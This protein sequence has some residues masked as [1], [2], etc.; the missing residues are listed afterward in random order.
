VLAGRILYEKLMGDINNPRGNFVHL[1]P[2]EL[3]T[4]YFWDKEDLQYL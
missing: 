3:G 1:I 4:I 2:E